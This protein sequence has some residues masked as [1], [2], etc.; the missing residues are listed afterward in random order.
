MKLRSF[1]QQTYLPNYA[2]LMFTLTDGKGWG[3]GECQ[4]A[5]GSLT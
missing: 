5:E 2:W 3:L 4:M 1:L